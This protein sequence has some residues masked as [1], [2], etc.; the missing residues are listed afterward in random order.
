MYAHPGEEFMYVLSGA[1]GIWLG[2][3]EYYRL[4][5]GDALI[6]ARPVAGG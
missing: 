4:A 1:L 6:V 2:D 3:R 5:E